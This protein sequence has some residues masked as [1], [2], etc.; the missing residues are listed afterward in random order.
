MMVHLGGASYKATGI[1]QQAKWLQEN[2]ALWE[3]VDNKNARI[4]ICAHTDF[5]TVVKN[6]VYEVV[7]SRAITSGKVTDLFYSELWQMSSVNKRKKLPKYVGFVQYRKYLDF[8]DKVPELGKL[9][10]ERGAITTKPIDLGMSMRKQYAT[11]GNPED[12]AIMT[13]I[14][15]EQYPDFAEAWEKALDSNLFHPGSIAIM[16]TEDWREMFAVAWSVANEYLK[17]IGGDIVA[18]VQ[19]NEK[20]YHIGEYEYTTLTN[21]IRVGGQICERIVSAWMDWKFPNAAQFAMVTVADKI[22][23]PFKAAKKQSKPLRT[24]KTN[25]K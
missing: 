23:V 3:P 10:E 6:D 1:K 22:E 18:R 4:F 12:L 15:R 2:R 5:E 9:I 14:V 20:A 24:K 19:A 25:S 16:K 8:M 7:D 21:E 13:D 17:R 11:W